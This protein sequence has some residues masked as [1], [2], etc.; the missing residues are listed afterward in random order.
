ME[1]NRVKILVIGY[2]KFSELINSLLPEFEEEAEVEIVESVVSDSNDYNALVAQYRPDVVV[3]AGSNAAYLKATLQVP[4]VSQPVSDID[5]IEVIAKARQIGKV[6]HV[7][8]YA[9]QPELSER[10]L[11]ALPHLLNSQ[12]IAYKHSTTD[13]ASENFMLAVAGEKPDVIVGSSYVCHLAEQHRIPA[14]LLYSKESARQMLFSAIETAHAVRNQQHISTLA[15]DAQFVV[16]SKKMKRITALARTYSK[17]KAPVLLEGESGTGKEH[18][19]KEI[20]RV[21]DFASGPFI[22]INCGT[23]PN[24]LFESELFGYV[25]GAFTGSRKGGQRGLIERANNGLLFLDEVGEMPSQQQVKIL[26]TLQE[27]RLRPVG[28]SREVE[29]DFKVVAAT[30]CDL[31]EAVAKGE[32]R[33]DLYFRLNVFA[34]KVPSLRERKEDIL[35]IATYYL[36]EYLT[37]Y[38][39]NL[40]P[41]AMSKHIEHYFLEYSWPGNVRELQNFTERL[42]VN[43]QNIFINGGLDNEALTEVLPELFLSSSTATPGIGTLKDREVEAIREAMLQ[44]DGDKTKVAKWLGIS[45]TTLWRRLKSMGYQ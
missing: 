15:M 45:T 37:R 28:G 31:R 9:G 11:M 30:N 13:E 19:A 1:V 35:A 44:F 42:V 10:L 3:S 2:R 43:S 23:I 8:T 38:G 34:I 24:E 22:P 5:L 20:H 25:E 33:E 14:L 12:V 32:F 41:V 17:G 26:R 4:V 29:V 40:D 16:H 6:I 36:N 27:R 18:I 39:V 7:F 21:S